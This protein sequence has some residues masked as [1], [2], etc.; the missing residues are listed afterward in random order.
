[1]VINNGEP[2]AWAGNVAQAKL[3]D[4]TFFDY[5]RV[6]Q[7]VSTEASLAITGSPTTAEVGDTVSLTWTMDE[8]IKYVMVSYINAQ[9]EKVEVEASLSNNMTYNF[10]VPDIDPQQ[11]T[12]QVATLD[13]KVSAQQT[14]EVV[15]TSGVFAYGKL[16]KL[17]ALQVVGGNL[18]L[19]R[20]TT[21][22]ELMDVKGVVL[23]KFEFA[24]HTSNTI[25]VQNHN[26]QGK[27]VLIKAQGPKFTGTFK[28]VIP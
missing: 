16:N 8:G 27:I 13:D 3:P 25:S 9:D 21:Y 11:I 18:I 19:P 7:Q 23:S 1:M 24:G 15:G 22:A 17:R 10:V 12:I 28:A 2:I 5:V 6:Y 20:N 14:I 4:T 26:L